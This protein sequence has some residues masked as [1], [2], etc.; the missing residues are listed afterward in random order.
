VFHQATQQIPTH[1]GMRSCARKILHPNVHLQDTNQSPNDPTAIS[2]TSFRKE[3]LR[4]HVDSLNQPLHRTISRPN[5]HPHNRMRE[6]IPI[7]ENANTRNTLALLHALPSARR[8][9][10]IVRF[11]QFAV[12]RLV[13][14]HQERDILCEAVSACATGRKRQAYRRG[15]ARR[16]P[17]SQLRCRR[18]GSTRRGT[19]T[20]GQGC[21]ARAGLW[22]SVREEVQTRERSQALGARGG[23]YR[24]WTGS[25]GGAA[26]A[27]WR[28]G[29]VGSG[30][31]FG[32]RARPWCS[33]T[34]VGRVDWPSCR[35][36]LWRSS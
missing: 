27:A 23:E 26:A 10:N 20:A 5:R 25:L 18:I 16:A 22:A 17:W 34:L 4:K 30:A 2:A 32:W 7:H 8:N 36:Q 35:D 33:T 28:S 21:A 1:P 15:S 11:D 31:G 14:A 6:P 29:T 13:V 12:A 9:R 24:R 19:D 3:C